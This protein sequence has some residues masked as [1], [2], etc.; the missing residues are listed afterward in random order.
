[1]VLISN[2]FEHSKQNKQTGGVGMNRVEL[3]TKLTKI[4]EES[5]DEAD[6][7]KTASS[8]LML[9]KEL[10]SFNPSAEMEKSV[11]GLAKLGKEFKD[12]QAQLIQEIADA[13]K[14]L[15]EKREILSSL[16]KGWEVQSGYRQARAELMA[17]AHKC[18]AIG[19]SLTDLSGELSVGRRE[20]EQE[21]YQQ[22]YNIL[23]SMLNEAELAKYS[24]ILNAF[25]RKQRTEIKDGMKELDDYVEKWHDSA[26]AIAEERGV[27]LPA[28]RGGKKFAGFIG[29]IM[30]ALKTV[31]P[32][33]VKAVQ[34]WGQDLYSRI[35]TNGKVLDI[36][37]A[38]LGR[39]V[40]Q[41]R[42]AM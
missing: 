29:D 14:K 12:G 20:S 11:E 33:L 13:E 27:T 35:T 25:F 3:G 9:A 37:D 10:V 5:V 42:S 38:K 39:M 2:S 28:L 21:S 18:M 17:Q 7:Q 22:K 15:D 40:A 31:I 32:N 19:D 4:A 36:M 26:K 16:Y 34:K 23:V 30:D 24:R 8:M 6:G 1:M 41:A